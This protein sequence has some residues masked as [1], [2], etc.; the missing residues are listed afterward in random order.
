MWWE[1]LPGLITIWSAAVAGL[2]YLTRQIWRASKFGRK[3]TIAMVRLINIGTAE[4]PNG[5]NSLPEAMNEIYVRQGQTHELLES[6]I[7]AHRADHGFDSE[8]NT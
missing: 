4:W 6:Y 7:V 5:A 3:V 2:I 1:S 8:R